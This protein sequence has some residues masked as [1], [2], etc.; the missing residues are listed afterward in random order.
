[1]LKRFIAVTLFALL[2]TQGFA[3]EGYAE[4][5]EEEEA[6]PAVKRARFGVTAE[7]GMNSLSSLLGTSFTYYPSANAAVDFGFGL[8]L[9]GFRP[10]VRGRY[11]IHAGRHVLPFV[12]GAVKFAMGGGDEP[13]TLT[14][15]SD[16][17]FGEEYELKIKPA[18]FVD[19][20]GGVEFHFGHFRWDIG[21]GWSQSLNQHNWTLVSGPPLEQEDE[22]VFDLLYGSGFTLYTA[23]GAW[24]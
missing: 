7:V 20:L 15:S 3:Q 16:D 23:L 5:E 1:M 8:S 21:T 10:G 22:D 17:G 19:F 6:V 18:T 24:F 9:G 2:S 13:V 14:K 4:E 11:I 12:G